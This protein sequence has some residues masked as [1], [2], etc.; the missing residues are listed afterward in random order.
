MKNFRI[1]TMD[2]LRAVKA[3]NRETQHMPK[4]MVTVDKRK[5]KNKKACRVRVDY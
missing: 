3:I 4:K 1:T 5:E 2:T